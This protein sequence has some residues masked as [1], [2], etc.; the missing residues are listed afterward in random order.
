[1]AFENISYNPRGA[2]ASPGITIWFK[3]AMMRRL[4]FY[5]RDDRIDMGL[6][7]EEYP[8]QMRWPGAVK[9]NKPP[10]SAKLRFTYDEKAKQIRIFYGINGAEAVTELP[11]SK[12]GIYLGKPYSEP[13]AVYIMMSNGR[14][15]LDRFEIK[16]LSE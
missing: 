16:P 11:H 7:D 2:T 13:T 14:V 4:H 9:C 1:M 5:I 10:T 6:A 15:D 3:D 12:A 8:V